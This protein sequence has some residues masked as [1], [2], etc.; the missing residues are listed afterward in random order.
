MIPKLIPKLTKKSGPTVCLRSSTTTYTLDARCGGGGV[1]NLGGGDGGGGGGG[2]SSPEH[3]NGRATSHIEAAA[4]QTGTTENVPEA[5]SC[6]H[7]S[8]RHEA[9]PCIIGAPC[10]ANSKTK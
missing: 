1:G 3:T 10:E 9:L 6:S 8:V 2:R 7:R 5:I 4:R